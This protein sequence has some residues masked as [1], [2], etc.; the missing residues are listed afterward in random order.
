MGIVR[1]SPYRENFVVNKGEEL[2]I[3]FSF[4]EDSD[5]S[6]ETFTLV[7]DSDSF[8]SP[9]AM[10]V[11]GQSV[12]VSISDTLMAEIPRGGYDYS[13]LHENSGT[14]PSALLFGKIIVKN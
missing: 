2:Y 11:S 6:D 4:D 5:I 10:A 12:S 1:T 3:E 8:S 13:I 14:G 9:Y 7:V